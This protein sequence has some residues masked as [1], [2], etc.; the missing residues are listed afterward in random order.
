MDRL[1]IYMMTFLNKETNQKYKDKYFYSED[2]L[3]K[4]AKENEIYNELKDRGL[5][6]SYD[7]LHL[8]K[9]IWDKDYLKYKKIP[10]WYS[11]TYNG[12]TILIHNIKGLFDFYMS[13]K[14]DNKFLIRKLELNKM[15]KVKGNKVT[16]L[17]RLYIDKGYISVFEILRKTDMSPELISAYKKVIS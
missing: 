4:F 10:D 12:H 16:V 8:N 11:C 3:Y 9:G 5:V 7:L 15:A 6:V 2:D 14:I 1:I 13:E 17:N